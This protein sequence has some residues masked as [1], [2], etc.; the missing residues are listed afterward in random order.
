MRWPWQRRAPDTTKLDALLAWESE[1]KARGFRHWMNNQPHGRTIVEVTRREWGRC[2]I[3]DVASV[4]PMTNIADLWWRP[5]R[6]PMVDGTVIL[7]A[8]RLP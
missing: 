7:D 3:W 5:C 4:H 2:E 1:Q 8:E 6:G